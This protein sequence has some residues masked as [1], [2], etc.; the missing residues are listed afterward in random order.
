MVYAAGVS[1][2]GFDNKNVKRL[3]REYAQSRTSVKLHIAKD[4][5]YPGMLGV[6]RAL[7]PELVVVALR[8]LSLPLRVGYNQGLSLSI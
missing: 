4:T 8:N 3:G 5:L 6:A 1:K 7:M 2:N